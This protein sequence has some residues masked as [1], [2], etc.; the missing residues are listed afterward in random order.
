MPLV[1][2]IEESILPIVLISTDSGVLLYAESRQ[3][4]VE[5]ADHKVGAL[6]KGPDSS[7]LAVV[8]ESEIW[9]RSPAGKWARIAIADIA[10]Q[11]LAF[12]RGIIYAGGM[13]MAAMMRVL[14]DG[15]TERLQSFDLVEGREEWFAGGP[16]LGIR[17]LCSTSDEA[18]ILAGVHVGGIPVSSDQGGSW[19]PTLPVKFDVHEVRSHPSRNNLVAAAAAVGLCI[20]DDAG[21]TWKVFSKE[22]EAG[23]AEFTCLAVAVLENEVLFSVQQSPFARRSQIWKW[24]IGSS[25]VQQVK[26]GLPEWLGGRVDTGGVATG[27]GKAAIVDCG[28]SLWISAEGAIGWKKVA[29]DLPY[30]WGTAIVES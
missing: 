13:D 7:L 3:A 11:S 16:P 28:G 5:L 10:L 18:T 20:S 14:P 23:F 27:Y 21:K 4:G 29:E 15:K 12:A 8:D 19:M 17:S 9:S 22:L 24:G 1:V 30:A 2:A 6:V 26:D 25:H